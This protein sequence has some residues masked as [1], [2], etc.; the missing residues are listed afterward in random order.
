MFNIKTIV[1]NQRIFFNEGKTKDIDFRI[2][3][4]EKLKSATIE[5]EKEILEALK[6]DL[7]KSEFEGYVTEI[8]IIIQEINYT[9]KHLAKW[10]RPKR[11]RT[12]I[13]QAISKS[14]IYSEPYGV[15]LIISPWNYPFQL[16]VGPLIGAIAAGNCAVLKPSP[17]SVNT[18]KVMAKMVKENFD[19]KYIAM[20]QG[21]RDVNQELLNEKFDHIFFTGGTTVGKVV[22]EAAAKYLTPVTLELGGKSPCIVDETANIDLAAKRIIWG[23]LINSGQTCLAPDYLLVHKSVKDQLIESMKKYIIQFYGK[24][25]LNSPDYPK[26]INDKHFNRLIELME[27]EEIVFGGKY[28]EKTNQIEPTIFDN[29]TWESKIMEDEIFGPFV[30]IL[31]FEDFNKVITGINKKPKPLALYLFTTSREREDKII[32]NISYGGGCINDT[33]VHLA[34]PYMPFGGVGNS[35]MGAYHGKWSFDTFSHKKS[36]LKKSNILDLPFRY[37]PFKNGLDFIK[38]V[39]K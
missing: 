16:I 3:Q 37:P 9:I 18:S 1:E 12:P 36:I 21:G 15:T 14:R 24:E 27:H 30:P 6:Q 23:K 38:K 8:G 29:V 32:N 5:H 19:E 17:Y 10:A 7:N 31:E 13:A 34:T 39:M 35:G 25:P 2:N 20:V 26:I 28:S 22:M 11:V 33:V 4:L